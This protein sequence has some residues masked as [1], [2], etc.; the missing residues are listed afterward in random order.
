[1]IVELAGFVQPASFRRLARRGD[2]VLQTANPQ[3]LDAA[4]QPGQPRISDD[5]SFQALQ[6]LV[7]IAKNAT[8]AHVERI[9]AGLRKVSP[10]DPGPEDPEQDDRNQDGADPDVGP[11]DD[12]EQGDLDPEDD[13]QR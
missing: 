10:D 11:L 3:D 12:I 4:A 1:M 13:Q 2:I 6:G 7:A 5:S 9:V 8:A